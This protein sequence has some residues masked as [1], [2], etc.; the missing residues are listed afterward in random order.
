MRESG[1]SSCANCERNHS[2]NNPGSARRRDWQ[3]ERFGESLDTGA[4]RT[5]TSDDSGNYRIVSVPAG[6]YEVSA[7]APGF[8]TEVRSGIVVTVGGEQGVNFALT[9]GAVSE[10]VEVTAEAAQVDTSS[11]TLA[12]F[13]N[14]ATIRELPLNGR[15]WLQL[16][17]LSPGATFNTG[18]NQLDARHGQRGNGTA[19]SISGGRATENA[20]RIDGIIVND[21]ANA[22][23]GSTLRVN[24]GVDAIREFSVL[25]N[26]YST[27]Y[28]MSS[29]GVVNA[30]T[31]SGTNEYHGGAYYFHR[32]SALDAR[33]FFD[34]ATIPAFRRHQFGGFAGGK[35]KKDK[36][37]F[38]VNY[39]SLHELKSLTVSLDTLSPNARNGILTGGNVTVDPRI[40]PYLVVYPLP[41]G[42]ING[43]TGKFTYGAP[44]KGLENYYV[45]KIDH[46]FSASTTLSGTYN[47]D[48]TN[49]SVPD[50]FNIKLATSPSRR[51]NLALNLQHLF[52]PTLIDTTRLGFSR[53]LSTSSLD[54]CATLPTLTDKSLGFLPGK[55]M[56]TFL[57]ACLPA[58]FS[59][60]G[61][62]LGPSGPNTAGFTTPQAYNDL[63]WTKGKTAC[64]WALVLSASITT[65]LT[66]GPSMAVGPLIQSRIF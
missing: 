25:T 21:Y 45:G 20:F 50:D 8:K 7:T 1:G 54:C 55:N 64:A 17:L 6:S 16:A 39:E 31:K 46:Y 52:G 63:S 47:Y 5:A 29:A 58:L 23:P 3:G 62:G 10:K 34:G 15:D 11:S 14:S 19:M 38:F 9:V 60:I 66:A 27:E 4:V 32:N 35:I 57:C 49:V 13:V 37:F 41:N 59:G 2:G 51:H 40:K 33:N 26:N 53:T 30:I 48:L 65:C 56:G 43:D 12:G 18:Q 24:L 61:A 44:R 22:G 42:A 28:G 36:T